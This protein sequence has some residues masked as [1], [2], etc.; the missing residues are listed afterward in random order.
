MPAT[1]AFSL[2]SLG[3]S[4][5]FIQGYRYLDRCGE[6]LIRLEDSL[7][8]AWIPVETSPTSGSMKN[9]VLGM[10]LT[11]NSEGM[12]VKQAEYLDFDNFLDQT[13]IAYETLWRALEISRI[14]TPALNIQYQLGF[15]EDQV[16]AAEKYLLSMGLCQT[17][18]EVLRAMGGVQTAIQFVLVSQVAPDSQGRRSERR[19]RLQAGVVRQERQ[20]SFD[21]R[22]L[23]RART[24]S[25]RQ[26]DAFR[27]VMQ[28][29]K[30]HPTIQPLAVQFGFEDS[31]DQEVSTREFNAP[32]FVDE[33]YAWAKQLLQSILAL[34]GG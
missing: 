30:R 4:V 32:D 7:D 19:R 8:S 24:L 23:Q 28:L 10:T 20:P 2:F 13:C 31:L 1:T 14:N 21:A 6:C 15:D 5:R 34:R 3:F 18:D 12:S 17:R 9:E 22:L 27:A 25:S 33:A 29:K 11:F 26:S 16:D